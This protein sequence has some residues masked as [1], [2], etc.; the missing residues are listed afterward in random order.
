M[1]YMVRKHLHLPA[2]KKNLHTLLNY[3]KYISKITALCSTNACIENTEYNI[4]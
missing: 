3:A 4:E 2:L 1:K